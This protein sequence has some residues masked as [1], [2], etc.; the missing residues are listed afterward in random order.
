MHFALCMHP[1]PAKEIIV[2]KDI[3]PKLPYGRQAI[4]DDD[5]TAVVNVLKDDWITTGPRIDAFEA[6]VAAKTGARF[7]VAVSS[8]TAALHNAC[9]AA[10]LGEGDDAVV[11]ALTFA[12]TAAA[13]RLTGAE[14][15]F[16]DIGADTWGL[17]ASTLAPVLTTATKAVLPGDFAGQPC[18]WDGL[19]ECLAGRDIVTI[20]DAAHALGGSYKGRAVG[21][22]ADMTCFSFHP[23]KAITTAEGGLTV[24]DSEAFEF[25]LKRARN[26]GIVR[27]SENFAVTEEAFEPGSGSSDPA[28]WYYEIHQPG[29]NYRISDIQC[30][31]GLS[32]LGKLESFLERRRA[33][34]AMYTDAFAGS[35]L[36]SAP[37]VAS[38]RESAWHIYV[39]QL[40]L[41]AL[42]AT[43]RQVFDAL[44]ARGLGVQVHYM[45]LHLHPYY[46]K[47]Y[48]HKRGDFP[49][50]EAYYDRA[51]SIPLF[52]AMTDADA[53][54]VIESVLDVVNASK[55]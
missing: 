39:I 5:I 25:D 28:P 9:Q 24:T 35:D 17:S 38:D 37:T 20:A 33:L 15:R 21:S 4:D 13:V 1:D 19:H 46:R 47:R 10:G 7:G 18:A 30:A 34:A 48:G 41:P 55:R 32:Q 14:V 40:N 12:A 45:P 31:L 16:S 49:N 22:L 27:E 6:A 8:G 54:R 26:H 52:P 51:L 50:A 53:A 11:P 44:Q 23:V 43:R 42:K 36:I 29:M 3:E 2:T